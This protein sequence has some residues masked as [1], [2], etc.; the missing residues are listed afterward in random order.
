MQHPL[1]D[2]EGTL[3]SNPEV[4]SHTTGKATINACT[5]SNC[6]Q[7]QERSDLSE[8]QEREHSITIKAN[9]TIVQDSQLG[10]WKYLEG[11]SIIGLFRGC[12][13]APNLRVEASVYHNESSQHGTSHKGMAA[14]GL[15]TPLPQKCALASIPGNNLTKTT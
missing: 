15:A 4:H 11:D 1:G 6:N 14:T 2:V 10:G 7:L 12:C 5:A 3:R 8:S 13:N 9:S